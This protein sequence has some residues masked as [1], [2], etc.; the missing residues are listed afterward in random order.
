MNHTELV[1]HLKR[2]LTFLRNSVAAYDQGTMEEAI[3]IAVVIRVLCHD[4]RKS[5]SLLKHIGKKDTLQLV[6]TA[7]A[8]PANFPRPLHFGELMAGTVF[9]SGLQQ[10]PVLEGSPIIPC[11]AW[12]AESVFIRDDVPYTRKDVV[13][14]ARA[15]LAVAPP[16]DP[17]GCQ[18]RLGRSQ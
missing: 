7:K 15:V 16:L 14:T 4:T 8:L 12:W 3:R 6:T 11:P 10:A 1:Q 13:L 18:A 17:H 5:T 9:G 2:Q